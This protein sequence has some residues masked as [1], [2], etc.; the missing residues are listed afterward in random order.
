M[1]FSSEDKDSKIIIVNCNCG[2]DEAIHIKKIKYDDELQ[3]PDEYYISIG[4]TQFYAK[5][6]GIFR[7]IGHRVKLA[8]LMLFGKEYRFTELVL[9]KDELSE[10]RQKLG[11]M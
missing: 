3:I 7:T 10:L 2:C 5:Q 4:T 9:T 8:F 1:V 6:K 11:D